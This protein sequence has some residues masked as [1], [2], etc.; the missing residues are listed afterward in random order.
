MIITQDCK[1]LREIQNKL[2][3]T[4]LDYK[5]CNTINELKREIAKKFCKID[6]PVGRLVFDEIK[7]PDEFIKQWKEIVGF[8]PNNVMTYNI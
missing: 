5:H 7:I 3:L 4:P 8:I 2:D 6:L 1:I